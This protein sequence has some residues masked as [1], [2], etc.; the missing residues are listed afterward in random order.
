MTE[1]IFNMY[2]TDWIKS[3]DTITLGNKV[4]V[5]SKADKLILTDEH[6][7]VFE[8]LS[9]EKDLDNPVFIEI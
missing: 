7:E 1:E 6:S 3:V 2:S 8:M 5:I 9:L 4:F